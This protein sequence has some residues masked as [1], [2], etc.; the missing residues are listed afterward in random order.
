MAEKEFESKKVRAEKRAEILNKLSL[1]YKNKNVDFRKKIY[2]RSIVVLKKKRRVAKILDKFSLEYFLLKYFSNEIFEISNFSL[3][4]MKGPTIKILN[5]LNNL[6]SNE[7]TIIRFDFKNYYNKLSSEYVYKKYISKMNLE[8]DER[9]F[10]EIF[11]KQVPYCFAGLATSNKFAEIIDI[12]LEN[13]LSLEFNKIAESICFHFC[14]DFSIFVNKVISKEKAMEIIN[15]TLQKVYHD[16]NISVENINKEK[17]HTEEDKFAVLSGKNLPL[18]FNFLGYD[19]NIYLEDGKINYTFGLQKLTMQKYI[20][21]FKK[22]LLEY[23][24]N[25]PAQKVILELHTKRIIYMP[26]PSQKKYTSTRFNTRTKCLRLCENRLDEKTV[27]FL[28][29]TFLNCYKELNVNIPYFLKNNHYIKFDLLYNVLNAKTLY[30]NEQ[31]GVPKTKLI[32]FCKPFGI[33]EKDY[34]QMALE[35]VKKSRVNY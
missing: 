27:D 17:I 21:N 14:D 11:V 18:T 5:H 25:I 31:F 29:N 13:E 34:N 3:N 30:F 6:N 35:L 10:L 23:K 26:D 2:F 24:D 9:E 22:T 33:E 28:K 32:E 4:N 19:Y 7:F 12:D 8:P 16:E 1:Q 20:N 15:K